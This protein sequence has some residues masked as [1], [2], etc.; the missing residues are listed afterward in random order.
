[1][2]IVVAQSVKC[3]MRAMMTNRPLSVTIVSWFLIAS[4]LSGLTIV[5]ATLADPTVRDLVANSSL[6]QLRYGALLQL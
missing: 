1:M 5:L 6:R 4:C 2:E 3:R